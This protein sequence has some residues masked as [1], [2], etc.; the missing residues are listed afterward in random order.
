MALASVRSIDLPTGDIGDACAPAAPAYLWVAASVAQKLDP[1]TGEL[2][3]IEDPLSGDPEPLPLLGLTAVPFSVAVAEAET[4]AS[5]SPS[6]DPSPSVQPTPTPTPTPSP[7]ATDVGAAE[8]LPGVPFGVCRIT[9]IP[10]TFGDELDTAWVFEEE[11]V[12]GAGCVNSEGFQRLALGSGEQI[13][14]MTDRITDV[15]ND[16]AWRVWVYAAPDLDGDG[17]DEIALARRGTDPDARHLWFFRYRD[18]A[19]W[20]LLGDCG[21]ACRGVPWD[22]EIGPVWHENGPV[23]PAGLFCA[24]IQPLDGGPSTRGLMT[25]QMTADD[26]PT[27]VLDAWQLVGTQLRL[28]GK[29]DGGGSVAAPAP[30]S[31]LDDLCGSVVHDLPDFPNY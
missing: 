1:D 5:A 25:W 31:G 26:P 13:E 15:L 7:S 16:D 29:I 2:F 21:E 20:P 8:T 23:T 4:G 19:L 17:I 28:A 3:P 24:P 22:V 10:G 27:L 30:P 14:V 18:G 6:D 12:P 9:S 11:R